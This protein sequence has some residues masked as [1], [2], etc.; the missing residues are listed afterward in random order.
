[1]ILSAA[2]RVA[3]V[4]T[5]S[6][7]SLAEMNFLVFIQKKNSIRSCIFVGLRKIQFVNVKHL[8]SF[9]LLN[10]TLLSILDLV[11]NIKTTL[12]AILLF[13]ACDE[14]YRSII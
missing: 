14:K 11:K 12:I 1:M 7:W 8:F 6:F 13:T 2:V 3:V 9:E 5:V 4:V 10:V